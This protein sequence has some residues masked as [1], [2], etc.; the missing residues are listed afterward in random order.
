MSSV[1]S[2]EG[3]KNGGFLSDERDGD[4][5]E[6]LRVACSAKGVGVFH[7]CLDFL[8]FSP[9]ETV[10]DGCGIS[11]E[12]YLRLGHRC[13]N[14]SDFSRCESHLKHLKWACMDF[15]V[16]PLRLV[17]KVDKQSSAAVKRAFILC[18]LMSSPSTMHGKI[19]LHF[20]KKM[21]LS[22]VLNSSNLRN[23]RSSVAAT[24]S[25][26]IDWLLLLA[27]HLLIL[28]LGDEVSLRIVKLYPDKFVGVVETLGP[29]PT[30]HGASD[31]ARRCLLEKRRGEERRGGVMQF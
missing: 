2:I 25:S 30:G 3:K 6:K 12:G 16:F 5:L 10:G 4:A 9:N 7:F 15:V 14:L 26:K 27:T 24:E 1:D 28:V 17:S 20:S 8:L 18:I 22:S 31:R 19:A 13:E 21:R 29:F 11:N 23:P